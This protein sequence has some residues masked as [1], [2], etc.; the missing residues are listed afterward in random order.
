MASINQNRGRNALP[1]F[2]NLGVIL[3][4]LL[5]VSLMTLAAAA[6]GT[7]SLRSWLESWM[8]MMVL[9]API[10]ICS[11]VVLGVA[12]PWLR[13]LDYRLAVA[14]IVILE[15]LVTTL[16]TQFAAG[17]FD[18]GGGGFVRQWFLAGLATLVLLGYFDLRSRA[19]SPAVTEA[20]LQALQA[21]IRPHFFFNS[22]NAVLSLVRSEPRRA[23]EALHDLAELFRVL[24]T[25]GRDLIPLRRELEICEQYLGIEQLR[26]GDRLRVE[27]R[28]EGVPG[29]AMVP[30]LMLQPVLENA[31]YHGIEPEA[32]PGTVTVTIR[33]S[34]DH[35]RINLCNP[36][37]GEGRQQSGN[38]MAL[39]NIR[40]R[41]QLHF[42][43]EANLATR[44]GNG[45]FEV[46][47][48]LPYVKEKP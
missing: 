40:E 26:L 21:R 48:S 22:I 4:T 14:L 9:V 29:D 46:E 31:V 6:L 19:L 47:I 2:R 33:R 8:T 5:G 43:A 24:M 25:D 15:L 35:L 37:R 36:Y 23:E 18:A 16:V 11:L 20:R 12:T 39:A 45:V 34:G 41:L 42:D 28:T 7:H 30:P 32:G 17:L 3:R 27:W 13:V 38:R 44:A 10:A 1:D